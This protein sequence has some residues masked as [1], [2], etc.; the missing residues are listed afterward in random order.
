MR[1]LRKTA[2]AF[3]FVT[4]AL[5]IAA[6][7]RGG[8]SRTASSSIK[9]ARDKYGNDV[10]I[11]TNRRFT[12]AEVYPNHSIPDKDYRSVVLLEEFWSE[13]HPGMEGKRA[14]IRVDGWAGNFP[15]PRRKAWT[16]LSEGDEGEV[17]DNFYKVTRYGCCAS[18]TT[19]V[20]FSLIDGQKVFTSN[21]DPI[22]VIVPNSSADLTR[23]ITWHSSEATMAPPELQT[24]KDLK[25]VLQYGSERKAPRRLL[26]RSGIDLYLPK[27]S[28][29]YQGKTHEDMSS[30]AS[31]L[32]LWGVDGKKDKSALSDFFV[33]LTW[34]DKFEAEIP[35][36]N[37]ELQITK[38]KVSDKIILEVAR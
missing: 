20:W 3:W 28:I 5:P 18:I 26:V 25:G 8:L 22:R 23:Y 33:I 17:R 34:S 24:V 14:K 16:I 2:I 29:R 12:F 37:D 36:E 1:D 7:T 13:W 27:I 30:L 10:I 32:T 11:T 15:N 35:V 21:I 19:H 38:A 9:S 4:I 6:Q 31:G